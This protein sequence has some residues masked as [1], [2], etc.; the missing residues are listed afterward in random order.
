[1]KELVI[2]RT[3]N[4]PQEKIWKAFT[5]A[6]HLNHWWGPTGFKMHTISL[7]LKPGGTFH[8]SMTAAD[9]S[10]MWGKFT[11]HEIEPTHKLVYNSSFSNETGEITR[12]PFSEH[13]PLEVRNTLT[14]E[15]EDGK[16]TLTLRGGPVNPTSEEVKLFESMTESMNQ[17]FGGTF[18]KLENY[19]EENA[20]LI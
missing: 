2:T 6:E 13:W 11:Y 9:G 17:G 5:E 3:F 10:I 1:M 14:L 8:Y 15:E 19:L 4:A 7:S 16:T 12:A 18:D 20:I